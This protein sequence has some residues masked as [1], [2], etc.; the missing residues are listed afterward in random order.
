MVP[1][2]TASSTPRAGTSSPAGY[3]RT[4]KRPSVR[5]LD[6]VGEHL[7]SAED[8]VQAA[9]KAG[10]QAPGQARPRDDAGSAV[11]GG[12]C[13]PATGGDGAGAGQSGSTQE[14]PAVSFG[15]QR[16]CSRRSRGPGFCP[17]NVMESRSVI[18]LPRSGPSPSVPVPLDGRGGSLR[19]P[20]ISPARLQCFPRNRTLRQWPATP[21][22]AH[23]GE[24]TGHGETTASHV[25][26]ARCPPQT[27]PQCASLSRRSASMAAWQPVPA[28]VTA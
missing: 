18:R 26:R 20:P 19:E 4:R 2:W 10:G 27:G 3:G 7:R 23:G 13:G 22:A 14:V 12:R 24:L 16:S 21:R 28:A 8:G 15:H 17:C 5:P 1:C 6:P 11:G 9:R 25:R